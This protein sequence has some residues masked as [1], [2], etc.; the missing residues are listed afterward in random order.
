MKV[1]R[2]FVCTIYNEKE[3]NSSLICDL[4]KKF[5]RKNQM[6]LGELTRKNL[7]LHH[8][9]IQRQSITQSEKR[10]NHF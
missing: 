10:L 6:S 2:C 4:L 1:Q 5:L 3:L 7:L 9:N 8:S